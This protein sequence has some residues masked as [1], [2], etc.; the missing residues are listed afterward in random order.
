MPD[1][2]DVEHAI[3]DMA[4]GIGWNGGFSDLAMASDFS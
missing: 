3:W 2:Q 1:A 4:R